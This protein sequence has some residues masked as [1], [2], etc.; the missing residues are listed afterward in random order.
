MKK[1]ILFMITVVIT[2]LSFTF[3]NAANNINSDCKLSIKYVKDKDNLCN[4]VVEKDKLPNAVRGCESI[5]ISYLVNNSEVNALSNYYNYIYQKEGSN[6][7]F[8]DISLRLSE[9]AKMYPCLNFLDENKKLIGYAVLSFNSKESIVTADIITKINYKSNIIK[10]EEVNIDNNGIITISDK[11]QNLLKG[12]LKKMAIFNLQGYR[13][14]TFN[15]KEYPDDYSRKCIIENTYIN[16]EQNGNALYTYNKGFDAKNYKKTI[17][18]YKDV[19]VIF[20]SS[21]K[22]IGYYEF[23][24]N[25]IKVINKAIDNLLKNE[26][27]NNKF[28]SGYTNINSALFPFYMPN[29]SQCYW[30][31]NVQKSLLP[32]NLSSARYAKIGAIYNDAISINYIKSILVMTGKEISQG[33]KYAAN[34]MMSF[35]FSDDNLRIN[36]KLDANIATMYVGLYDDKGILLTYYLVPSERL[37]EAKNRTNEVFLQFS[38]SYSSGYAF[39]N[40]KL[41]ANTT[42]GKKE[43]FVSK[44]L[45]ANSNMPNLIYIFKL[46]KIPGVTYTVEPINGA[47]ISDVKTLS[48]DELPENIKKD[49]L[50]N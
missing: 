32:E 37:A 48:I 18:A 38:I 1:L 40:F 44:A 22:P 6:F 16:K 29:G 21:N 24:D 39:N 8:S 25:D 42:Q 20:D 13:G 31:V 45:C 3:S 36:D 34:D 17:S 30:G 7:Y 11:Q 49:Y 50:K 41:Y 47:Q 4:F 27:K 14:F 26:L 46:L 33:S 28:L 23:T 19:L 9:S 35:G 12:K 43:M 15:L 5:F 2:F 10:I